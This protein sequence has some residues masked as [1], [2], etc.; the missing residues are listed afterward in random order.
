[1][2]VIFSNIDYNSASGDYEIVLIEDID[3]SED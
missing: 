1:M 2:K 3:P